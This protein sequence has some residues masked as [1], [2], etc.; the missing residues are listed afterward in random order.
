M[1]MLAGGADILGTVVVPGAV[2]VR[3]R[4]WRT[5][6]SSEQGRRCSVIFGRRGH[7]AAAVST[8]SAPCA[9]LVSFL[10]ED[11]AA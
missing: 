10:G 1:V 4:S 6:S 3:S 7:R 11:L 9:W 2:T 8:L 5:D